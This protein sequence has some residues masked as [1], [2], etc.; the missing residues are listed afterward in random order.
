MAGFDRDYWGR[1]ETVGVHRSPAL[2]VDVPWAMLPD[3][4]LVG[5]GNPL[6]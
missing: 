1:L 4:T 2:V 5:A 3:Q 6:P